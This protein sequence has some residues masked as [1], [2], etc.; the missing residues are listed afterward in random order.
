MIRAK[1]K[2]YKQLKLDKKTAKVVSFY[3]QIK[4]AMLKD[5]YRAKKKK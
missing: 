2:F 3:R 5:E 1:N 4:E